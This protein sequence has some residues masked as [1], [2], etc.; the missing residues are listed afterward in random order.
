MHNSHHESIVETS[1]FDVEWITVVNR[2]G[3]GF[4]LSPV[5]E[6]RIAHSVALV[7]SYVEMEYMLVGVQFVQ[8]DGEPSQ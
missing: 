8:V 4:F 1:D 3:R 2:I 7:E 5:R 6:F